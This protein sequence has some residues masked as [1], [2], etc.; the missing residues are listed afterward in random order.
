MIK[1]RWRW[2]NY[3]ISCYINTII[4]IIIII[5]IITIINLTIPYIRSKSSTFPH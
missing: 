3:R 4:I 1:N 2:Q 5:I